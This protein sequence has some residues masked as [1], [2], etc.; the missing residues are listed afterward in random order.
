MVERVVGPSE[1][2]YIELVPSREEPQDR[3][4]NFGLLEQNTF[5]LSWMFPETDQE[6][7]AT[8]RIVKF[9]GA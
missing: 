2:H 3:A 7:E 5:P 1:V 4:L 9:A 8:V 6:T